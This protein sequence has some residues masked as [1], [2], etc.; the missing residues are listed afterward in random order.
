MYICLSSFYMYRQNTVIEND[1]K[2]IYKLADALELVV[3][4]AKNNAGKF[5]SAIAEKDHAVVINISDDFNY[6]ERRAG[7]FKA[8]LIHQQIGED[9][10]ATFD[11]RYRGD[12]MLTSG[13]EIIVDNSNTIEFFGWD[14]P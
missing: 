13:L 2:I 10:K 9:K 5:D 7:E 6:D 1:S 14:K 11:R 3:K 8:F 4:L 12:L